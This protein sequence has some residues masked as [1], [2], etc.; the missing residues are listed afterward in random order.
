M[1]VDG[2]QNLIE[3]NTLNSNAGFGL[4]F[5]SPGASCANTFG[6]NMAR[7]NGGAALAPCGACGGVPALFPPQSCNIA[8]CAVPNSTFG[9]NLIPG[10]PIF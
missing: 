10:P 9:D 4:R 7:G 3:R 2:T 1:L 6:R 8:G 5:C